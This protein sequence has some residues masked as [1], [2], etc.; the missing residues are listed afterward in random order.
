MDT[1]FSK[2]TVL[3][4]KQ[5]SC[6]WESHRNNINIPKV[7]ICSNL[8]IL[9]YDFSWPKLQKSLL[10]FGDSQSLLQS[11]LENGRKIGNFWGSIQSLKHVKF[12]HPSSCHLA[13][14]GVRQDFFVEFVFHPNL[15][16][17][18]D[19]RCKLSAFEGSWAVRCAEL[20]AHGTHR[21]RW[22]THV[23][24]HMCKTN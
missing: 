21:T 23:I 14:R 1:S 18:V 12:I 20:H 6:L 19:L 24:H 7:K 15:K 9:S 17:S 13:E 16:G 11:I 10:R 2:S 3:L 8:T 4:W 22:D 5:L